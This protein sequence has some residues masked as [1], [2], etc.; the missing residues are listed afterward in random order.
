MSACWLALGWHLWASG[1]SIDCPQGSVKY[2]F[3]RG[4]NQQ[5]PQTG[6]HCQQ[7]GIYRSECNHSTQETMHLNE[8]FPRCRPSQA[9]KH[10]VSWRLVRAKQQR[11]C[12]GQ[13]TDNNVI[14]TSP[15]IRLNNV[16]SAIIRP[17]KGTKRRG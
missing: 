11:V 7:A 2:E 4:E 14:P 17:L 10:R 15:S 6:E 12:G 9:P 16:S 5:M 13:S 3:E 8:V 1:R